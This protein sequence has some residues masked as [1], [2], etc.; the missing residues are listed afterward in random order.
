MRQARKE[1][2]TMDLRP[3]VQ[4]GARVRKKVGLLWGFVS[5]PGRSGLRAG[6]AQM[7]F[8]ASAEQGH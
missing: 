4:T 2:G 5:D 3:L 1:T 8:A 7:N 6:A